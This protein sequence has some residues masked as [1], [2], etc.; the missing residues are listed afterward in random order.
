MKVYILFS[1]DAWKSTASMSIIN[2]FS[3]LDKVREAIADEVKGGGMEFDEGV[4]EHFGGDV[5]GINN[6]LT[7]GNVEEWEV[8]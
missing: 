8:Q 4:A 6:G 2:V 1:C 7:Y 3:S 5:R